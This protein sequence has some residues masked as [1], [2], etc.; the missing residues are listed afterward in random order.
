MD[1]PHSDAPSGVVSDDEILEDADPPDYIPDPSISFLE[2]KARMRAELAN[3]QSR[4][5]T[6]IDSRGYRGNT[7]SGAFRP[8]M[9]GG[10]KR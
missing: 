6:A 5:G 2:R 1:A 4:H 7:S 9:Y 8:L 10:R 3:A